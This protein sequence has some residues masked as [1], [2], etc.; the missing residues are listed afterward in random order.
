MPEPINSV[1]IDL[2]VFEGIAKKSPCCRVTPLGH[3]ASLE[4]HANQSR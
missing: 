2:T 3:G 1:T 4:V